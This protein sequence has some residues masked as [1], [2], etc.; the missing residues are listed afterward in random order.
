MADGLERTIARL[1]ASQQQNR[2]FVA[3]VAHELRT[4]VTALVAEAP[5]SRTGSVRCPMRRGGQRSSWSPTSDASGP[6]WRT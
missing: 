5:S 1:D 3:D 2:V 6:W 4:P